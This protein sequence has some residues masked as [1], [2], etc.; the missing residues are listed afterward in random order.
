MCTNYTQWHIH[1]SISLRRI[2][3]DRFTRGYN[4]QNLADGKR[5]HSAEELFTNELKLPVHKVPAKELRRYHLARRHL[6]S[7][8]KNSSD[9]ATTLT[10]HGNAEDKRFRNTWLLMASHPSLKDLSCLS[11]KNALINYRM[12]YSRQL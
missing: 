9:L 1:C 3:K 8:L 4:E 7:K 11:G 10:A 2:V 5:D 6:P 12:F